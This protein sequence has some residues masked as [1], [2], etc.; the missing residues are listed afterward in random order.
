MR[1]DDFYSQSFV[2]VSIKLKIFQLVPSAT[3]VNALTPQCDNFP[4]K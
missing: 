4:P 3:K 2:P 1:K